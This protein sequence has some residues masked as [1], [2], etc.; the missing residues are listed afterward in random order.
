MADNKVMSLF[1]LSRWSRL[2]QIG[3]INAITGLSEMVNQEIKVMALNLEEVSARNAS[4]LIG[5]PDDMVVGIYLIFSGQTSGQIML[6]FQPK[7]A[8]E[9]VDMAIG[10]PEGSTKELGEMERS[11]LGEMGNIVGT[12][13]LNAVADHSGICLS[14]S[15]PA[16]VMDMSGALI[17]SV[18]AE[19]MYERESVFVIKLSF[20]TLDRQLEG[21]F[22]VL[23]VIRHAKNVAEYEEG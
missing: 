23:P 18:M 9:L 20:S 5:K 15:P 8:F 17:A 12:F 21:R 7:I 4:S 14:P 11:V 10:N 6:A 19:A 2:A 13:F 16:V 3:S 22:L 1:D